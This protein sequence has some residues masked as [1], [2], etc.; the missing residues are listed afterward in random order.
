MRGGPAEKSSI[1]HFQHSFGC[2]CFGADECCVDEEGNRIEELSPDILN[3]LEGG[4]NSGKEKEIIVA[5]LDTGIVAELIPSEYLWVNPDVEN[6][7]E[8]I[9]DTTSGVHGRNF[10]VDPEPQV[11][12]RDGIRYLG[13]PVTMD[14]RDEHPQLHGTMMAAYIIN[15]FRNSEYAVK[16]MVLKTHNANGLGNLD[17]I[18]RA[19]HYAKYY[20]AHFINA[21]WAFPATDPESYSIL[22]DVIQ[23][24][25][26]KAGTMMV[27]VSGNVYMEDPTRKFYPAKFGKRS[28]H[29]AMGVMVAATVSKDKTHVSPS[30]ARSNLF[31]DFGV[32][33]DR[34]IGERYVFSLPLGTESGSPCY[35]QGSSVAC[36]VAT[37][38]LAAK[39]PQM[40][41]DHKPARSKLGVLEYGDAAMF[42]NSSAL[43]EG[44][45]GGRV[46]NLSNGE[47]QTL[48]DN[49]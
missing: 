25:L 47:V 3:E 34:E 32:P 9:G 35:L 24:D 33:C 36:A 22:K 46:L 40:L 43:A 6:A 19:I 38:F 8:L 5:V 17:D 15:Q 49:G 39:L 7:A 1:L 29:P 23:R 45:I 42:S 10:V 20:G 41:F 44:V 30:E 12:T 4:L 21:S 2:G 28:D 13:D 16:I 48:G 14:L 27:T 18:Y 31:V 26:A 11:Q 37:G